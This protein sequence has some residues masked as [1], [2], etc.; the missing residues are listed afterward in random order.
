[1][2]WN[3]R[4]IP[5]DPSSPRLFGFA[6]FL[7]GL[8]LMVVAWTVAGVRYRFRLR[9]APLPLIGITFAIMSVVG[10]LTL[11]T[12][13]W[14]AQAWPVPEGNLLTPATWQA[15]LGFLSLVTFL[16][17]AWFGFIRPS[18]FGRVNARRYALTLYRAIAFG[19]P[20]EL[21]TIAT[22][23]TRSVRPIVRYATE[24]RIRHGEE[25]DKPPEKVPVLAQYANDMLRLIGD[26][27][28]CHAIVESSPGTAGAVFQEMA[29]AAKYRIPVGP[30]ARN[31]VSEALAHKNSFLFHEVEGYE[32]GL[33]GAV[34]P[35]SRAMFSN[36]R[37][38]E[39]VGTLL[40]PDADKWDATQWGAYC[41]VVLIAFRDYAA[42]DFWSHSFTLYRAKERIE[43]AASDLYRL[44]GS[45]TAG[46]EED[47]YARLRIVV[48]FIVEAVEVLDQ[49]GVPKGVKLRVREH[50]TSAATFYDH[51]AKMMFEVIF[52][53]SQVRSPSDLSW[54]VQHNAVWSEFFSF[55]KLT[56][57]AGKM[58]K[59][60]LRRLL[61]DEIVQMKD[62]P[63]YKGAKILAFCL[64][65]M[66]LRIHEKNSLN[67]DS[68]ALQK[69]VLSW[70]RKN[71][72]RLHTYN[73]RVMLAGFVENMSYNEAAQQIVKEYV[74]GLDREPP[75]DVFTV[76]RDST[77]DIP[78]GK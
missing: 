45:A 36:F 74:A 35:L 3:I 4:L 17:W 5:F 9:T 43:R 51:L 78:T 64:N 48:D 58:I 70:T 31:V 72:A 46:W 32:S 25:N 14:R 67:V 71:F 20:S 34:K 77:G 65:V 30:F 47:A 55:A 39:S 33:I 22:E 61:Y 76:V 44:N 28:F 75:R 1:L 59:F 42:K 8:A 68:L 73:S 41:R 37:L 21:S 60:K 27:R 66:G 50:R 29:D 62:F 12:D 56:G 26:K 52:S 18:R 6:E 49:I 24:K 40:D 15:I 54:S 2:L 16:S 19:S 23:F 53:A 13:L 57:A 10:V 38:V 63:N 11:L 7:A 69:A